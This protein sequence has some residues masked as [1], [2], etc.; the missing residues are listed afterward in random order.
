MRFFSESRSG[1]R[2][3]SLSKRMVH[4]LQSSFL[5]LSGTEAESSR[6]VGM[7][8]IITCQVFDKISSS[9]ARVDNNVQ[10]ISNGLYWTVQYLE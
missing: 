4:A 8:Y 1:T 10:L 5:L 3:G 9:G 6:E 2:C 7:T